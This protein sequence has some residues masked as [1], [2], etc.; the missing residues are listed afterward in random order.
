MA[1]ERWYEPGL[2]FTCTQCGK[3]C[4]GFEGY[5]WVDGPQMQAIA[6]HLGLDLETFTQRYVRRVGRR[7]SLIEKRNLDCVFW[8]TGRGC[9]IYPV[10][11]TQCR[12]FPFWPEHLRN[13]RTWSEVQAECPGVGRGTHYPAHVIDAIARGDGNAEGQQRGSQP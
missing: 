2:N 6:D 7:H 12:T 4:T 11:P 1:A 5:V 3:C 13:P 8:E 9:T 10:R